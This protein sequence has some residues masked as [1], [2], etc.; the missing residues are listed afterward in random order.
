MAQFYAEN[1]EMIKRTCLIESDLPQFRDIPQKISL[2][3]KID[4]QSLNE[5]LK[6]IEQVQ[7][8]IESNQKENIQDKR[9]E[10]NSS[11]ENVN[12]SQPNLASRGQAAHMLYNQRS[13]SSSK[14]NAPPLHQA[15]RT[16]VSQQSL[17]RRVPSSVMDRYS[18]AAENMTDGNQRQ[19][20]QS[21]KSVF[22]VAYS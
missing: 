11:Y 16:Q 19:Q 5:F 21:M 14:L 13:T 4:M 3:A 1:L 2:S 17:Q 20:E 7:L 18:N 10:P 22:Q 8:C 12:Q 6:N 15:T 9:L